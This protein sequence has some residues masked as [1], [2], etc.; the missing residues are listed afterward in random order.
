M[1]ELRYNEHGE[2]VLPFVDR[3][4]GE[5]NESAKER[6]FA[7]KNA[8]PSTVTK[9]ESIKEFLSGKEVDK[10]TIP[11]F[12]Y[13]KY[14]VFKDKKSVEKYYRNELP[15]WAVEHHEAYFPTVEETIASWGEMPEADTQTTLDGLC[16]RRI[17]H[18]S[19]NMIKSF[20]VK[21]NHLLEQGWL[22]SIIYGKSL[23]MTEKM[24]L[25]AREEVWW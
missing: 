6:Y 16:G 20:S 23:S 9:E 12:R 10:E 11:V 15:E 4:K 14:F 1:N 2:L 24:L 8:S 13:G 5:D 19:N 17:R 25:K 18:V 21:P 22:M 3:N 7:W